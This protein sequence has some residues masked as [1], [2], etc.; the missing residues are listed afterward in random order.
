MKNLYYN[1]MVA[2]MMKNPE[3]MKVRKIT[4]YIYNNDVSLFDVNAAA[5]F[6]KIHKSVQQFLWVQSRKRHSPFERKGWGTY[7]LKP[8]FV[9]QL[10]LEFED[11]E[12]DDI[13]IEKVVKPRKVAEDSLMLDLFAGLY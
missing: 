1:D 11:W 13:V 4:R 7:A 9:I 12:D 6:K 3:G 5:K 10:E 2:V 8:N